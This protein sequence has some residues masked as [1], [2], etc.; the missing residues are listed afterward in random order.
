MVEYEGVWPVKRID[1]WE[2][3]EKEVANKQYRNWIFRGHLDVSWKLES[4]LYRL[5]ADMQKIIEAYKGSRRSF[6][7]IQHEKQLLR[8][9]KEHAHLY[10][11]ILP[12]ADADIEWLCL[13]QHYGTPTRLLDMTFSPYVAVFFA[14][15]TGHEDCCVYA[16][17]HK[18]FTDLDKDVLGEDYRETS[19]FADRRG[20]KSYFFP[21]EPELKD[22]RIVAQQGLFLVSSNNYEP[23]DQIITVYEVKQ[24]LKN[25]VK[26]KLSR[27]MRYDGLKK[28]RVMNISRATLFPGIDGFCQSLKY[29]VLENIKYLHRLG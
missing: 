18:C 21:Y 22:E 26:Y 12:P 7:R 11:K 24:S 8:Q 6:S 27:C 14:L 28:L 5:F 16:L 15:E 19:V 2:Q 17:R 20:E 4:S 1:D 10:L 13:M 29:Q 25:C 3:F 23:Y 9:F